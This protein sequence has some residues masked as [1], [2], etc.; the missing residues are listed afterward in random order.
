MTHD[1]IPSWRPGATRRALLEFLDSSGEVSP[2][3]RVAVF[4]NDGTLWCEMPQYIQLGFFIAELAAAVQQRPELS[5]R[6]EY[7]ALLTSDHAAMSELGLPRIGFA[8]VELFEGIGPEEFDTR[9]R[10]YFADARHPD[11]KV[12]LTNMRYGPMLELLDELR[13]R[14]FSVFVV[15]GGGTEFVRA[16]ADQLYEVPPEAIVGSQ[17][18]YEFARIDGRPALRRT[19][20]LFGE[21]NEGEAKISNIRRIAGRRPIL[22][23]GN[24]PGDSEMLEYAMAG[25]GPTLALLVDHDDDKREY[26][27]RSEAGSFESDESITDVAVRLGWTV[28][29]MRD[30]WSRIFVDQ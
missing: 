3:E 27:Y 19:S 5:Q 15:T 29:S 21:V 17:V 1:L 2:S 23:A 22:A 16:I 12:P 30:D 24:S 9:V 14:Q 18:G 6:P 4:D 28:V 25:D 26:A 7:A 13:A 11:R 8:L 20:E 10:R